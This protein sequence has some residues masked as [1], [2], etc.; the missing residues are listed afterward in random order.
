MQLRY[1][2]NLSADEYIRQQAWKDAELEKCPLHPNGG[3]GFAGH[4]VYAREHP[5]GAKVAR[6][7]CSLGHMTFS[8]L[9]D[10]LSSSLCGTLVEVEDVVAEVENSSSQEAMARDFK[11]DVSLPCLLSWIRRRIFLVQVSLTM[12]ITLVPDLFSGC[13]PTI[14]SFRLALGVD[15]V[16]PELRRLAGDNIGSL[17]APIGFGPRP[18]EKK[19]KKSISN[20]KREV[21]PLKKPCIL[22]S[23]FDYRRRRHGKQNK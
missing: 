18:N 1:A 19:S 11:L 3:C 8:L 7:Y 23:R 14:S 6:W 2:T 13:E 5:A 10:C 9:P 15:Y 22:P 12:L 17:P 20:T 21:T 16:L 4:G